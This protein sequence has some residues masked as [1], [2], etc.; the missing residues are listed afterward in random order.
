MWNL[1]APR[2]QEKQ[3]ENKKENQ[4]QNK[5]DKGLFFLGKV[6]DWYLSRK[7]KMVKSN[8]IQIPFPIKC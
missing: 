6:K 7:E 2:P 5:R 3:K 4:N 1:D 8:P